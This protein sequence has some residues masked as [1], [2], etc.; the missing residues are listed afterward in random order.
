MLREV[1]PCAARARRSCTASSAASFGFRRRP[2]SASAAERSCA[3]LTRATGAAAVELRDLDLLGPRPR[4][5]C[6]RRCRWCGRPREAR[7]RPARRS[8][9][10]PLPALR[11]VAPGATA[12]PRR[13]RAP[14]TDRRSCR[15]PARPGARRRRAAARHRHR[16]GDPQRGVHAAG[17]RA[18]AARA[19]LS[20]LQPWVATWRGAEHRRV[21]HRTAGEPGYAPRGFGDLLDRTTAS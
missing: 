13:A 17:D 1:T 18:G 12:R 9:A 8:P 6:R 21:R 4:H 11:R 15:A 5:A 16:T 19:N 10:R 20:H 14:A 7:H 2:G 3:S